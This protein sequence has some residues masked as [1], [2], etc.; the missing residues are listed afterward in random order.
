ML[1]QTTTIV[2]AMKNKYGGPP[3]TKSKVS[4]RSNSSSTNKSGGFVP[5]HLRTVTSAEAIIV[6]VSSLKT[7]DIGIAPP[8]K[9]EHLV[10]LFRGFQ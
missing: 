7:K 8:D 5:P 2:Q 9:E 1:K 3:T 10:S 4:I 6:D